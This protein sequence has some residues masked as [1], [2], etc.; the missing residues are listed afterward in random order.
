M[1]VDEYEAF[2]EFIRDEDDVKSTIT[3]KTTTTTTSIA[4]ANAAAAV[5]VAPSHLSLSTNN[6]NPLAC[7]DNAF[8]WNNAPDVVLYEIFC[9]LPQKSRLIASQ[10]CRQWRYA[11]FHPSF[12]KKITFC[13]SNHDNIMWSRCLADTY[14]AS[15]R[16]VTIRCDSAEVFTRE[17]LNILEKLKCNR[18]LRK[19]IIEPTRC[20]F[21]ESSEECNPDIF[22]KQVENLLRNSKYLE[23]FNLGCIEEAT[24]D[25]NPWL[26]ILTQNSTNSL[27]HL[28]LAS[29]KEDPQH[30]DYLEL[31][32]SLFKNFT[33][34]TLLAIDYDHLSND[35]LLS[36]NNGKLERLVVHVHSYNGEYM[37][38]DNNA[39][40]AF[41]Q[42]NPKCELRLNLIH[43]FNG[44][45]FLDSAILRP[46]MPLTHIKVLFC[47][48][49]N[50]MGL[51]K[52][53]EWYSDKL[54][55]IVWID[56]ISYPKDVERMV[57]NLADPD[58]LVLAAW[59]C[60]N[61]REIVH[62]GRSYSLNNLL[63]IVRVKPSTLKRLE[64]AEIDI[65][66]DLE[67]GLS[68]DEIIDEIKGAM[69]KQWHLLSV[70]EL[71]DVVVDPVDSDSRET[72][73]PLVF[74]DLK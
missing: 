58:V 22:I 48:C 27:K 73:L 43:S 71:P 53:T 64:F 31:Q 54:K 2:D 25:L 70:D 62:F 47:E 18:Q 20:M 12:W 33:Q 38:T 19:L 32:V 52:I 49:L 56:S 45:R 35:L 6:N 29:V 30:Y 59:K 44:V 13:L 11:L 61:L 36:L 42:K 17:A 3:T 66:H 15:V 46:A 60:K 28:C 41:T 23:T 16:E 24:E 34:L 37:G 1:D 57:D 50:M 65:D 74:E 68:I 8:H 10:V 39:W 26:E 69:G 63:G 9:Y 72:I 55:S 4:A 67:C 7:Q 14:Y 5:T 21:E 51:N 40:L